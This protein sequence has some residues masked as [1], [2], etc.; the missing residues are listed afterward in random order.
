MSHGLPYAKNGI[1]IAGGR[2]YYFRFNQL[3]IDSE[4]FKYF[5]HRFLETK[6]AFTKGFFCYIDI[7]IYLYYIVYTQLTIYAHARILLALWNA[8]YF[9]TVRAYQSKTIASNL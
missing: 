2:K 7:I 6:K 5:F 1:M 3:A 9:E 4:G 8:R